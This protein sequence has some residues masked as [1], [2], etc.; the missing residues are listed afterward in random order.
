MIPDR[1]LSN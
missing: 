1:A